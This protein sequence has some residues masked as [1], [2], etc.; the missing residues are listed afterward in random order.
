MTCCLGLAIATG[1]RLEGLF[2]CR[3]LV[4]LLRMRW[5]VV[6]LLDNVLRL[7]QGTPETAAA[8]SLDVR[9]TVLAGVGSFVL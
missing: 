6:H 1:A 7:D 5:S 9:V 8:A 3:A 4:M 2:E